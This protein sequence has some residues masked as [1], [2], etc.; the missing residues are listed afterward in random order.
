MIHANSYAVGWVP[1]RWAP[2][3]AALPVGVQTSCP[4]TL[5]RSTTGKQPGQRWKLHVDTQQALVILR[6]R[7]TIN[8]RCMII[9]H[10][11]QHIGNTDLGVQR[12]VR[13]T[14][15]R[16]AQNKHRPTSTPQRHRKAALRHNMKDFV[17]I[18]CPFGS[19]EH[20]PSGV[21]QSSQRRERV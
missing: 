3:E 9:Y 8:T 7:K 1:L 15:A 6:L 17:Q 11:S 14:Y 10:A 16:R 18:S 20:A 2:M 5:H 19:A 4:P 13:S 21:T 12:R